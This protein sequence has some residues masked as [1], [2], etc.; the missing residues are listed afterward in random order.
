MLAAE[1]IFPQ[2]VAG[3]E[4]AGEDGKGLL[5]AEKSESLLLSLAFGLLN[6]QVKKLVEGFQCFGWVRRPGQCMRELFDEH[7]GQAQVLLID[8][9]G[10]LLAVAIA[11]VKAIV[12]FAALDRELRF[13]N[14]DVA[15]RQ[16]V[17]KGIEKGGGIVRLDIHHGV[18]G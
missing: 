2:K 16:G 3:A 14:V 6:G 1:K 17:G 15:H 5:V 7:R 10:E 12:Q 8:G 13:G 9:I 11:D 4:Q 18:G